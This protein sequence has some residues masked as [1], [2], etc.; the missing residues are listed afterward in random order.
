[1]KIR[2]DFPVLFQ[3]VNGKPLVYLDNAATTQKPLS[4]IRKISEYYEKYNSNIHRGVHFLSQKA[5]AE[6]ENS[7]E[8]VRRF[9]N[10]KSTKEIIF[11][12]GT[13]EGINLVANSFGKSNLK[14]GDEILISH[15]EHHSN[16]VPWQ[17]LCE[18]TGAVLKVIPISDNGELDFDA[19]KNLL[20]ERTKIVGIVHQ[21]N[22]LGTENPVKAMAKLAHD[23]G[24]IIVV[25]GA[26]SIQ[27][28]AVDVQDLDCDFYAFSGHKLYGPTGTGVL[29]GKESLLSTMP[30]FQG[31]GDMIASVTFEKTIYNSLPYKFEA[32]TPNIEGVIALGAAI[33]YI[34]GIGLDNIYSYEKELYSYT[35]EKMSEYPEIKLIGSA[36]KKGG[37]FSF[38]IDNIHPHD[39]GTIF[40]LEGVAIRTGH[41]CTQPVMKRFNIP[42]VSR[43]SLGIYNTKEDIDRAAAVV[44][45][46]LEVFA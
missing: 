28:F 43:V 37:V 26:Q 42:A 9:I 14:A 6:Y 8:I 15:M 13:T 20:S 3:E 36:P 31:G 1:M 4:V 35:A 44:K 2:E 41:L 21:S 27:H 7:R 29:F 11:L 22:T 46:V 40:D 38:V 17:L 18:V 25:D 32:G 24:A 23:A 5:T 45:K 39:I 33:E 34:E 30:P 19:Y 16:I 12:R 10:A